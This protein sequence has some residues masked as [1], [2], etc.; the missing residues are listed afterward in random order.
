MK[1]DLKDYLISMLLSTLSNTFQCDVTLY[2]YR[3]NVIL[4]D[5]LKPGRIESIENID[6]FYHNEHCKLVVPLVHTD[7]QYSSEVDDEDIHPEFDS[8]YRNKAFAP[9]VYQKHTG[10][11]TSYLHEDKLTHTV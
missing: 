11:T 9:S 1:V 10:E 2:Q 6:L 5:K 4:F 3:R 8:I 7:E